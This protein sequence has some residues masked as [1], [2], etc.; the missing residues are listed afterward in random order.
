MK[1]VQGELQ[2]AA[3]QGQP[4]L[5]DAAAERAAQA[6]STA[7]AGAAQQLQPDRDAAMGEAEAVAGDNWQF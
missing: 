3:E 7:A 5:L 4:P 6:G 1:S 2:E